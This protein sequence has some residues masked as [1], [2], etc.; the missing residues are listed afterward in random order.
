SESKVV[1]HRDR[2]LDRSPG[3]IEKQGDRI[4]AI[5]TTDGFR[6]SARIFIDTGYEGDLMAAAGVAYT[7][8]RESTDQYGER[9][10]GYRPERNDHNHRFI[11]DVS[12]YIT[13]GDA[14]SGLLPGIVSGPQPESGSQD[15]GVQAYCFRMCLT[16]DP[17][18][19]ITIEKPDG[20]DP[21]E[22]ELLLRNFEAGDHRLPLKIDPMPNRKTDINNN[23]AVSTDYIGQNYDYPTADYATRR[24][25]FARHLRYQR[26]LMWTLANSDR[27]PE[28]IRREI[29]KWG[30]PKDEFED[31]Q[32][33]PHTIYIREARRMVGRYVMTEQDCRRARVADDSI[34]LGSYNM[35][36]HNILRYITKEGFVQNEGDIQ[37]SP[38]GAYAISYRSITP[39]KNQASNLLVP[40]ALSASHMAFGSIRMEPVFMV[41]GQSAGAAADDAIRNDCD[42]QDVAYARLQERLAQLGQVVDI[43]AVGSKSARRLKGIVVDDDQATLSGEWLPSTSVPDFGGIGYQHENDKRD[44]SATAVYR[45]QLPQPG[46]YRVRVWYPPNPNRADNVPV[47]VTSS[48]GVHQTTINMKEGSFRQVLEQRLPSGEL[49]IKISNQ[50]ANGYVVIDQVSAERI[51]G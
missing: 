27:V 8:G 47:T 23:C 39:M 4:T 40:V 20:Y 2:R 50:G 37:E 5:H 7:V 34:G 46:K 44:G 11:K 24:K 35:D 48:S 38:G 17:A 29:G 6:Y 30:V 26:G 33:W 25:I 32:H 12:P 14:S 10:A 9:L 22:Y 41:L 16:D 36:S 13:P 49:T 15:D 28:N 51:E 3:G 43:A 21:L 45:L 42:V 18:N 1:V 31:T 19:R